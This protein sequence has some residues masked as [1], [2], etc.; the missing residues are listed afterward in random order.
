MMKGFLSFIVLWS[1]RKEPKTGMEIAKD[2]EERRGHMPSPGT[3]YPVLK[4]MTM[5]GLLTMDKEKRYSL[6][7]SGK[8]ELERS[9]DHFFSVFFDIEEMKEECRC[10]KYHEHHGDADSCPCGGEK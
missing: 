5:R 10:S 4:M 8:E 7:E 6:T 1:V 2:L 9:L 3:I